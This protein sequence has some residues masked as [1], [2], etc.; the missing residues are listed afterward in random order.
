MALDQHERRWQI[1]VLPERTPQDTPVGPMRGNCRVVATRAPGDADA[2]VYLLAHHLP[3]EIAVDRIK[4]ASR[5]LAGAT[6]AL[7]QTD[8]PASSTA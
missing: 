5:T 7:H 2:P 1:N 3:A 6:A 4:A 8:S